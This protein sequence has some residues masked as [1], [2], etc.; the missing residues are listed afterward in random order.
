[1]SAHHTSHLAGSFAPARSSRERPDEQ[2][3]SGRGSWP[4]GSPAGSGIATSLPLTPESALGQSSV[5]RARRPVYFPEL[6]RA[7]GHELASGTSHPSHGRDPQGM[8]WESH[9]QRS[10]RARCLG[11]H[12]ENLP[13]TTPICLLSSSNSGLFTSPQGTRY[14]RP[15][16]LNNYGDFTGRAVP[17]NVPYPLGSGGVG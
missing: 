6:P 9:K 2:S 11:Q 8:G 5:A 15:Y 1:M 16:T 12:S 17:I 7:G 13:P 3:G 10:T 14:N 4:T